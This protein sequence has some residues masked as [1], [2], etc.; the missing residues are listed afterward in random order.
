MVAVAPLASSHIDETWA[1]T[2]MARRYGRCPRAERMRSS[3]PHGH[4]KTTLSP[5]S[6]HA[7]SSLA[8][9]SDGPID[10]DAFET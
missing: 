6:P 10:R 3:V 7:A 1:S 2:N 9:C 5:V 4:W 8:G